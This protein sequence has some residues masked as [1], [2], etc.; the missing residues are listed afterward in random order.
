MRTRFTV[1]GFAALVAVPNLFAQYTISL[2]SGAVQYSSGTVMIDD[3]PFQKTVTNAPQVKKGERLTT[4]VD[5]IAEVLLTPGVFVRMVE[6]SSLRMDEVLLT[7]TRVSVLQ[8]SMMVECAQ[9]E[10]DNA[11]VFT[12]AGQ[13]I[14]IRK[15]GLFRISADPPSVSVIH[16]EVFVSGGLNAT[17]GSGKELALNSAV[18]ALKKYSVVKDDLYQFSETRSADSA[19][20]SNVASNSLFSSGSTCLGS[21]WFWMS[22]VGMYSYIPCGSYMS[23]FG[24]PFFG[25][26][27]GYLY[28][29]Y[30][31]YYAPPYLVLGGGG[32]GYG[33]NGLWR[34]SPH[35]PNGQVGQRSAL[36]ANGGTTQPG[37]ATPASRLV[38]GSSSSAYAM[39]IP[40]FRN[41]LS[42]SP[43]MLSVSRA[44]YLANAGLSGAATGNLAMISRGSSSAAAS[45]NRFQ[46]ATS[47]HRNSF[48]SESRAASLFGGRSPSA[49]SARSGG[50]SGGGSREAFVS[51]SS[52]WSGPSNAGRGISSGA[53]SGSAGF[54]S[55]SSSVGTAGIGS[56][57]GGTAGGGGGGGHR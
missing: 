38:S 10:K 12:L 49:M 17:V 9:M 23:P 31:Y 19:Y 48:E 7:D 30:P 8:G 3:H 18:P 54:S 21:T 5:G 25:M 52:G 57:G 16:G 27:Y 13:T 4:G 11:V 53:S 40:A 56:R 46:G 32:F 51:R 20:A 2:H 55:S 36:S 34:F 43:T 41:A 28:D 35:S 22:A 1:L 44:S 45:A 37:T 24:Y 47:L 39:R 14:E 26:N 15:P 33:P 6:N 50:F 29:G 42:T